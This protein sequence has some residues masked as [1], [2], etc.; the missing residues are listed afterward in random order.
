M[1]DCQTVLSVIRGACA[2]DCEIS[3]L[4]LFKNYRGLWGRELYFM[5]E[6]LLVQA[7]AEG[8]GGGR[9]Y[10]NVIS[11]KVKYPRFT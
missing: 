6:R 4:D 3:S 11:R 10:N 2:F 1:I 8:R 9:Y 5:G 7:R